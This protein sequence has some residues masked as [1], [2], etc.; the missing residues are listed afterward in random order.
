MRGAPHLAAASKSDT[1]LLTASVIRDL[2]GLYDLQREWESL[3]ADTSGVSPFQ[4]PLWL[5]TWWQHFGSGELRVF[6]FR[7]ETGRLVG[8]VPCFL[9]EWDGRRQLTLLGSGISDYLEP[10]ILTPFR[11]E[12]VD[13]LGLLLR[14]DH[15]WDIANWQDLSLD[16]ALS[17]LGRNSQLQLRQEPDLFCSEIPVT[18]AFDAYWAERPHGL[19]RNVRRYSEKARQIEAPEFTVTPAYDGECLEALISLHSQRWREQGESGMIAANRSGNFLRDITK[20]LAEDEMTLFFTLR[21]QKEVVAV[22]L[23][24]PYRNTLFSYLSAF[25]PVHRALGF[26]RI[27]LYESLRY[28]FNQGYAS[29]NFL[30]GDEPYKFDWGACPIPKSRLVITR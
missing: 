26:G 5:L 15:E 27:L 9:H 20:T 18:C 23:S 10:A 4:T 3:L 29:W 14:N 1:N 21:F 12:V 30:R 25:D 24:F 6:V 2:R 11:D 19:K 28:S 7:N 17:G 16:S 13:C 8:V 22:I